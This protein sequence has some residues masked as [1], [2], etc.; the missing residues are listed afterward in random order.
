MAKADWSKENLSKIVAESYSNAEV[1]RA[2]GLKE[3]GGSYSQLKKYIEEYQL[4]TSHFTGALWHSNPKLSAEDKKLNKLEDILKEGTNYGSDNLKK[5]LIEVGYKEAK[6]ENP[7]C[8]ITEWNGKPAPLELHHINGNHYDNRL[9]NLQILCCNCHAQ[10][11]S[12]KRRMS[13]RKDPS[14]IHEIN[15]PERISKEKA[16]SD[17]VCENPNCGKTFTPSKRMQ[18]YCCQKCATE[19]RKLELANNENIIELTE[20]NIRSRIDNFNN[21]TDLAKEL[22][23]SRT[24]MRKH[25]EKYGL[26]EDFKEKFDFRGKE[27]QQFDMNGNL[28]QE[29][30]SIS[31]AE[32][33]LNLVDIGKCCNLQ[34]KSCGGYIWRFKK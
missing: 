28:I 8:G 17:K 22:N 20:E 2:L 1:I 9:E 14:I 5:R 10:T 21:I 6:C 4:D 25:L 33:T 15:K 30:P 7:D 32:R 23:T 13:S 16:L 19:A 18:K 27:I 11:D 26:L 34:R 31:D 12:Y 3:A 29:W 24:T